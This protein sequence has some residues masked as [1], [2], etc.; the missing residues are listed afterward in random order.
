MES[1]KKVQDRLYID[2]A[3]RKVIVKL[4]DENYF[5]F[6]NKTKKEQFMFAMAIGSRNNHFEIKKRDA[7]FHTKDIRTDDL[8]LMKACAI[9]KRKSTEILNDIGEIYKIAEECAHSGFR[10]L[11]DML[12]NSS[13]GSFEKKLEVEIN[14]LFNEIKDL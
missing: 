14:D 10:T 4:E 5:N 2:E 3:D 7:V 9:N 13:F 6:R 11:S 1:Y 8:A 12:E